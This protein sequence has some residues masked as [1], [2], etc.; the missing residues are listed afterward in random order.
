MQDTQGIR[1]SQSEFVKGKSFLAML[2]SSYGKMT[3]L[4]DE[5]QAVDT[6]LPGLQ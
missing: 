1:P 6:V 5:G 3:H 4:V 2:M